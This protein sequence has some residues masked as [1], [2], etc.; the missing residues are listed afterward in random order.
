MVDDLYLVAKVM[1]N[2]RDK[3]RG[4]PATMEFNRVVQTIVLQA[5]M[6]HTAQECSLDV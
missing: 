3:T 2:S 5:Y 4:K 6:T 1:A